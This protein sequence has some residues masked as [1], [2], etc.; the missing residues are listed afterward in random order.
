MGEEENKIKDR[1]IHGF[2]YDSQMADPTL[3]VTL[4][5]NMVLENGKWRDVTS[6]D[7]VLNVLRSGKYSL[8]RQ[9]PIATAILAEDFQ[10]EIANNWTEVD[11]GSPIT[12]LWDNVR[13]YSPMIKWLGEKGTEISQQTDEENAF[14][15]TINQWLGDAGKWVGKM[16][17]RVSP[18]LNK[19][20]YVQGTRFTYYG[21]TSTSFGN[22]VMKYTIFSDWKNGEFKSVADQLSELL[23]YVSGVY[24]PIT[25]DKSTQ[26]TTGIEKVD[27]AIGEFIGW[28]SPPGGY[29][30]DI[31]SIEACMK[32]TLRLRLGAYYNIDNLVCQGCSIN[33]SKTMTKNPTEPSELLPLYAEVSLNL[34]PATIFTNESLMNFI[35][36]KGSE[37]LMKYLAEDNKGKLKKIQDASQEDTPE[38]E[39]IK[40]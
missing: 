6:S 17:E 35:N 13:Q 22:L 7:G 20:M 29:E 32:G 15:S 40:V 28:Q 31:K 9:D 39:E 11:S 26:L 38:E 33:L 37:D 24:D 10:I 3:T 36:S 27:E 5:P 1:E 4:H 34:K 30:A 23:P 16:G 25:G 14:G 18:F 2:Y 21:G 19:S 8:Y 12:G